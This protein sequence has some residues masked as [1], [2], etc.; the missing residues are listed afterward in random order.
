MVMKE[1]MPFDFEQF[2]KAAMLGLND[3][4]SLSFNVSDFVP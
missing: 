3:G 4:K 2:K 1:K